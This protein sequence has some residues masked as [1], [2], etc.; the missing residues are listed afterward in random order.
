VDAT[1]GSSLLEAS[2]GELL[3]A[4]AARQRVP[5]AGSIA[6]VVIAAAAGMVARGARFSEAGWAD[7]P[8][9]A[10]QAETLRARVTP[11]AELAAE[12]FG[13]AIEALDEPPDD[14]A[15]RR[16]W[17]LGKALAEAAEVPLRIV[18]AGADTA[19]LAAEVAEHGSDELRP[20]VAA[21]AVL[22]EAGARMCA[23][24]VAVNLGASPGDERIQA[25]QKLCEAAR[26][27]RRRALVG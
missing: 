21:A 22:A 5:G 20:D 14:D 8:G 13:R 6:A 2:V 4:L 15:E 16:D 26:E 9:V 10:A 19:L 23:H 25:A 11:L 24:L 27:A 12:A 18:A 3:D 7:A 17:S 1:T